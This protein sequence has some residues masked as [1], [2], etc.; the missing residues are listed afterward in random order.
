[1]AGWDE[2]IARARGTHRFGDLA[3][4]RELT[5]DGRLNEWESMAFPDMLHALERGGQEQLT[6]AQREAVVRSCERLG[7]AEEYEN[8]WSAGTVPRGKDVTVNVGPKVLKP[9][10][11]R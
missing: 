8:A 6:E 1:M 4:L 11:R 7:V 5:T 2:A 9:P 3:K 10:G